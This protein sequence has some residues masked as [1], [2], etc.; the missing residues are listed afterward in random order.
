M[1]IYIYILKTW[2]T[3]VEIKCPLRQVE[4]ESV[5]GRDSGKIQVLSYAVEAD[6][7]QTHTYI[8]KLNILI[9]CMLNACMIIS[10]GCFC[11]LDKISLG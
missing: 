8:F 3:F 5:K 11:G 1:H 2:I 4:T 6:P 7:S 10:T 9:F